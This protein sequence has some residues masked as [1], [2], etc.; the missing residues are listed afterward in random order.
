MLPNP[1]GLLHTRLA[2]SPYAK[3]FVT[4]RIGQ[5]SVLRTTLQQDSRTMSRKRALRRHGFF[6]ISNKFF[7]IGGR[8]IDSNAL[9]AGTTYVS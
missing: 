9:A 2:T 7:P 1:L 3:T 5:L 6:P 8:I 4:R